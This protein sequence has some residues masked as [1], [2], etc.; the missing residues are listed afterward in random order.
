MKR[1]L[2]VVFLLCLLTSTAYAHSGRTDENGGHTDHSTGEYHYHHGYPAHDHYDMDGDGDVDCPYDFDDKTG[3]NSG[4]SSTQRTLDDALTRY[5]LQAYTPS[6]PSP[7]PRPTQKPEPTNTEMGIGGK[8]ILYTIGGS[9]ALMLV[10]AV[11]VGIYGAIEDA[12]DAVRKKRIE[13]EQREKQKA[14]FEADK[15]K[16]SQ[17]YAGKQLEELVSFPLGSFLTSDLLPAS[18]GDN[19]GLYTLFITKEK[20]HKPSCRY[21]KKGEAIN[22]YEFPYKY[23]FRSLYSQKLRTPCSRC[24]PSL[25]DVAW[26]DECRK[27]DYIKKKYGI[28]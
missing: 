12:R 3:Q 2:T 21:A 5:G 9:F 10:G 11:V 26:V 27:I 18:A 15:L 22:S 8:I 7:T 6:T 14:Q 17:M 25:P 19:W 4:S 28:N 16:Y 13:K 24:K 20:Y 23:K 1:I